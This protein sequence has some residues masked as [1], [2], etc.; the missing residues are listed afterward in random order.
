M[1]K[2]FAILITIFL[3]QTVFAENYDL[4]SYNENTLQNEFYQLDLLEEQ[5]NNYLLLNKEIDM[6]EIQQIAAPF[7]MSNINALY[8][9]QNGPLGIP[10]FCWGCGLGVWGILVVFLAEDGDA[11]EVKKS[12][13]G[14]LVNALFFGSFY[15]IDI[16]SY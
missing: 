13:A 10:S 7:D 11:A 16:V 3:W 1:K 4:F 12:I 6:A 9:T 15:W 14:C 5:I 8:F 2:L